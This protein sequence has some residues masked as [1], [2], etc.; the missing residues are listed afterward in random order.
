MGQKRERRFAVSDIV[1]GKAHLAGEAGEQWMEQLDDLVAELEQRWE[2]TVG[3]PMN[4]GSRALVFVSIMHCSRGSS[5][6]DHVATI[7][8]SRD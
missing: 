7:Y 8:W 6:N 4:G 2:I 5:W 3:E 1:A